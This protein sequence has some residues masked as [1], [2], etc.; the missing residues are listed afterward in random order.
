MF[1]PHL[2]FH[3]HFRLVWF[4]HRLD[5]NIIPKC[6]ILT[7]VMNAI[8]LNNCYKLHCIASKILS[9]NGYRC[10]A[11][12]HLSRNLIA[13]LY[14]YISSCSISSYCNFLLDI[15]DTICNYSNKKITTKGAGTAYFSESPKFT[16]LLA[17]F[18]L[19]NFFV[20]C[21]IFCI[22]LTFFFFFFPSLYCLFL[23]LQLLL[24]F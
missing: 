5:N 4:L 3:I 23:E 21:V 16:P 2:I 18:V 7:F 20:F 24:V 8:Y 10:L 6:K 19:L 13:E 17:G 11:I 15:S 1:A 14:L 12:K 9:E 22:P